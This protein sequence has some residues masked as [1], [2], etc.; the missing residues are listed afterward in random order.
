MM[1]KNKSDTCILSIIIIGFIVSIG[2]LVF[3]VSIGWAAL[4]FNVISIALCVFAA[5]YC[6]RSKK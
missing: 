6:W 5:I 4:I 1:E 3:S 2:G